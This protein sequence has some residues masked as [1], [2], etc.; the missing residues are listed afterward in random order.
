MLARWESESD[1]A[2]VEGADSLRTRE[3]LLSR[4]KDCGNDRAW[5]EF[6]E[7]YWRLIYNFARRAG[8]EDAD[9]QDVVQEV[10]VSVSRAMPGFRYDWSKGRFR[11]WMLTIVRARLA[12]HWQRR[13]R[14]QRA[15][16]ACDLLKASTSDLEQRW[17]E[18]WSRHLLESA[19]NRLRRRTPG[20]QFLFFDMVERQGIALAPAA[21]A[22]GFNVAHGYVIRHRLRRILRAEVKYIDQE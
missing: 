10:L 12:D 20:R 17:D 8:L 21:A 2:T 11:T 15:A 16:E 18:E 7:T 3:S 13:G 9:A 1:R 22:A 4:L 14:E 6:F 19:M 5:R